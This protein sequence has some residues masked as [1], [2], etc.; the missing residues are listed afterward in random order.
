MQIRPTGSD[1]P[2]QPVHAQKDGMYAIKHR[3]G[4]VIFGQSWDHIAWYEKDEVEVQE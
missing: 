4:G 2:F 3:M 1:K